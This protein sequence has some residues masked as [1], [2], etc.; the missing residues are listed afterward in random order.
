VTTRKTF[1]LSPT[2][3]RKKTKPQCFSSLYYTELGLGAK[4]QRL[5]DEYTAAAARAKAAGS[6]V[7]TAKTWLASNASR[8]V[9]WAVDKD[10]KGSADAPPED[11]DDDADADPDHAA[12]GPA[13]KKKRSNMVQFRV[14]AYE[15]ALAVATPEQL[16]EAD[17]LFLSQDDKMEADDESRTE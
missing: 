7:P 16:E 5:F 1:S 14:A 9:T 11:D 13:K 3:R 12:L 17:R 15:A 10:A 4:A 8:S 6:S 2:T